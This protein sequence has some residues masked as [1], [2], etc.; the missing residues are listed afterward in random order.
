MTAQEN[1]NSEIGGASGKKAQNV[2]QSII[3][4]FV[5]NAAFP[6]N[7]WRTLRELKE[8]YEKRE[9]DDKDMLKLKL[10]ACLLV[11]QLLGQ[12]SINIDI[13]LRLMREYIEFSQK[14]SK[15]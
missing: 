9:L 10:L 14:V 12:T 7:Y 3:D 13:V 1:L 4:A 8:L 2:P 11:E 5:Y 15:A 6:Q